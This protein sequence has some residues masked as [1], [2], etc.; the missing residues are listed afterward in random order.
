MAYCRRKAFIETVMKSRV[1][2]NCQEFD[3]YLRSCYLLKECAALSLS[4][5]LTNNPTSVSGQANGLKCCS[6]LGRF[7]CPLTAKTQVLPTDVLKNFDGRSG[8]GPGFSSS[9]SAVPC[10]L[11]SLHKPRGLSWCFI[12]PLRSIQV[13]YLKLDHDT[14]TLH[15]S[16]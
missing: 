12:S 8:T 10:Q 2:T 16:S 11:S 4:F 1:Y 3:I 6:C 7:P 9:D 5:R 14:H 15:M 13:H